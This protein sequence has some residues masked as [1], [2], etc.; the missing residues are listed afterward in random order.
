MEKFKTSTAFIIIIA[1]ILLILLAFAIL[2][3][4]LHEE[5]P[6]SIFVIFGIAAI[7]SPLIYY[8]AN[9]NNIKDK[10]YESKSDKKQDLWP[11]VFY[12]VVTIIILIL[13]FFTSRS[14]FVPLLLISLPMAA[15]FI[16]VTIHIKNNNR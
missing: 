2:K 12:F 4:V 13:T 8:I 3:F 11:I 15:Y 6:N 9:K 7:V 5:I 1:S 10:Q 16:Y 14:F